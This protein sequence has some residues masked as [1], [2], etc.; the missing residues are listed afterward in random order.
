MTEGNIFSLFTPR[1][2][3]GTP[4]QLMGKGTP[5][6]PPVLTWDGGIPR[7][8]IQA[9]SQVRTGWD[10]PNWNNTACNCYGA[11]GMPLTFTKEDF[12]VGF[13]VCTKT[14]PR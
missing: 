10:T 11:G 4:I 14:M 6:D 13:N 9:R 3:G 12:L 1:G 8:P 7:R 5:G 2:G